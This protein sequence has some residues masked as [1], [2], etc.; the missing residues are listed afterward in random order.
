MSK[1]SRTIWIIAG[2]SV[3]AVLAVVLVIA[4]I[5]SQASSTAS[6]QTVDVQLGTLT[7]MVEGTGTVE[8]ALS[9]NLTWQ[10][11]GQV[12]KVNAQIGDQVQAGDVLASMLQSSLTQS[13]LESN[14]VTAQESLA[15]LTSPEA[16]ANAKLAVTTAQANVTNAQIALNNQQ[17]W[18]NNALIQDQYANL[19]IAKANLDKAQAAYD[20]AN[21]GTYINN[22]GEAALYQAL[23]NAQQTYNTA[24]FNYSLYSQKPTQRQLDE[25]QA[26]L[27][28]AKA[29]LTEAQ[30]YVAALTGG[31]VPADATGTSLL[32]LKQAKLAVQTAQANLDATKLTAPFDGTIT[33][34]NAIS[35]AVVSPG[36]QAFRLDNLSNLV[37]AVQVIE[38]DINS[39]KIGQPATI[40]FDAI[41]NKTYNGKVVEADLAGTAGQNSVNYTVTVKVTDADAQVKPGMSANVSIITNQV[42]NALLVPSTAILT[43]SNG[44]PYVTLVQNGMLTTVQVTVGAT[45]DTMSQ[46]TSDNLKEGDTIV[47]SFATTTSSSSGGGGFGLFGGGGVR[48]SGGG[49]QP[50]IVTP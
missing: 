48:S 11:S 38:I 3:V 10:T 25:A 15:E 30:N 40:T 46:I 44:K 49:Q 17:Y 1:K 9:A 45:S 14:L 19:V 20:S 39:I 29:T 37:V 7:S 8:S 16:I 2:I 27:D 34:A 21:V 23:Y 50:V 18:K 26:T 47:L 31:E 6:Y 28:L 5:R 22:S 33:Q 12:E 43:D 36:T 32:K 13:A 41:P 35:Q 24:E 42:A 4:N